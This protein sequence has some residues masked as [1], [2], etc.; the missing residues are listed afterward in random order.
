MDQPEGAAELQKYKFAGF[1]DDEISQYKDEQSKQ[2]LAAGFTNQE[3]KDYWGDKDP[4]PSAINS[5]V[6]GNLQ[7]NIDEQKSANPDKPIEAKSWTD[8]I[9]AGWGMSTT[10]LIVDGKMPDTVLPE[11]ADTAM[12]VLAGASTFV[13]D[14]PAMI[15]GGYAGA[16]VGA[17][18]GTAAAS[19]PGGIIGAGAGLAAGSV[20]FP[21][22]LRKALIDEYREGPTKT[23]QE[24]LSR[25]SSATWELLKGSAIGA[26]TLGVGEVTGSA[27]AAKGVG[28]A[29]QTLGKTG[30]ELATF[31]TMSA[32]LEGH[33]PSAQEITA[34]ALLMGGIHGLGV[35]SE[36]L[37]Q[38]FVDTGVHPTEIVEQAKTDPVLHQQLL[39][40][41][42]PELTGNVVKS[43]TEIPINDNPKENGKIIIPDN[44][45][46]PKQ[47]EVILK[48]KEIPRSEDELKILSR[49]GE[50]DK[51]EH[52][53]PFM[54][55]MK[56]ALNDI[57]ALKE[58]ENS[59]A[60]GDKVPLED[61]PYIAGKLYRQWP[62]KVQTIAEHGTYEYNP[63]GGPNKEGAYEI[64]GEGF[65]QVFNDMPTVEV[66][67]KQVYDEDGFRAYKSSKRAV[68]LNKRGIDIGIDVE[69]AKR[70]IEANPQFE[71]VSRRY[72]DVKKRV[73]EHLRDVGVVDQEGF[74]KIITLS[75]E[76][77][78][79]HVLQEYDPFVS[80]SKSNPLMKI[81]GSDAK[82]FDPLE[83][84][85]RNMAAFVRIS[86]QRIVAN[87]MVEMAAKYPD[88]SADYIRPLKT[89]TKGI[90][91]SREEIMK[92]LDGV[93]G[94]EDL[95]KDQID[96][97][98][99]FR[100]KDAIINDNVIKAT[101]KDG[102]TQL[103][104]VNKDIAHA[105]NSLDVAPQLTGLF[106]DTLRVPGT[107]HRLGVTEDP[108]FS[109]ISNKIRDI[110]DLAVN[111]GAS[112]VLK[113]GRES[114]QS[115]LTKD[116]DFVNFML[117]GGA[118]EKVKDV[119][120]NIL[121]SK[122]WKVNKETG[123]ID[124]AWNII[125]HPLKSYEEL[126]KAVENSSRL[127]AF[128]NKG[129]GIK[130]AVAARDS[131]VD[132][133][134]GSAYTR[135]INQ[136]TPFFNPDIQGDMRGLEALSK[137]Q[138]RKT[139]FN[140]TAMLSTTAIGLWWMNKDKSQYIAL[141]NWDKIMY[142]HYITDNWVPAYNAQD[143]ENRPE[144]QRRFNEKTQGWEVNNANVHRIPMPPLYGMLFGAIY[145]AA[146]DAYYDSHGRK[147]PT[148]HSIFS[149]L[150]E[151][152]G[153]LA[154]K[155]PLPAFSQPVIEQL[156][157]HQFFTGQ[158]IIPDHLKG[159]APELQY[160]EY[161]SNTA[162]Q[163]G[164]IIGSI[165]G[166]G[167]IGPKDQQISSPMVIDNYI[168]SWTGGVGKLALN[169][170][171]A[172]P[173]SR[174]GLDN[175]STNKPEAQLADIPI[176]RAL[177]SRNPSMQSSIIVDFYD[178]LDKYQRNAKSASVLYK[179]AKTPE[180]M[181]Q[182]FQMK[183]KYE[184]QLGLVRG[185]Q[186]VLS[187]HHKLI[188]AIS[189][190]EKMPPKDKRQLIDSLYWKMIETARHGNL[191]LQQMDAKQELH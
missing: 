101:G 162:R 170:L 26:A 119:S 52:K 48:Q 159:L 90:K 177:E 166:V 141:S 113:S 108:A 89:K 128:K 84:D 184:S 61:S 100:A 80:D 125:S 11:H 91:V 117:N 165:P 41:P 50:Q 176:I 65:R 12:Q 111:E 96:A 68:E 71:L 168:R 187:D 147:A 69:A 135:A 49:F 146:L 83:Q 123:V 21:M 13:G 99:I 2:Y 27:L 103:F 64:N 29:V 33:L 110:G 149:D 81:K 15:A 70:V 175:V 183:E 20:G 85:I 171:D 31:T 169:I 6:K 102:K 179:Q 104:E 17:G 189:A 143:A 174:I 116:K 164:K 57:H 190:D 138:F 32:A 173:T 24:F 46:T 112:A 137:G 9:K 136:F 87:K 140:G 67:G 76:H 158:P 97:L 163:L 19:L 124:S 40:N 121:D 157:N 191:T 45:V 35:V 144:D 98:T 139:F 92:A 178:N 82:K 36:N 154:P 95:D 18:V 93:D 180:Q 142:F 106:W 54:D 105:L 114:M 186:Q 66:N 126:A 122:L 185:V 16:A 133:T 167:S 75:Q 62:A 109:L 25:L 145:V 78:P 148:G 28:S 43:K 23:P 151:I 4:D 44:K 150:G 72:D 56:I 1:S 172:L 73:I 152:L 107:L 182:A 14:I 120:T 30:S 5:F 8:A 51:T 134:L 79:M 155:N 39:A 160:T 94:A 55:R 7:K 153:N 59:A 130:G 37:G 10:G 115:I 3:L 127:A 161:T 34:N 129:G 88:V 86:Q 42:N 156:S 118:S 58:W 131:T 77:F 181:A 38:K 132:F 60:R 53:L 63:K 22:A 47:E 188:M 74:E